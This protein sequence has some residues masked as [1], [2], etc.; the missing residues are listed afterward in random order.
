MAN[1]YAGLSSHVHYRE[2]DPQLNPEVAAQYNIRQLNQTVVESGKQNETLTGTTEQD[3]TNGI[4]KV[5]R[6]NTKTLCFAQGHGEKDI[7]GSDD[8]GY[9]NMAHVL[10][11]EG[12][13]TKAAKSGFGRRPSP[14]RMQRVCRSRPAAAFAPSGIADYRK[15]SG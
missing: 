13:Q 9:A 1:D 12:Y 15:I 6:S 11:S 10:T 7:A 2:V 8:D 5:T 14:R 4:L 3:L